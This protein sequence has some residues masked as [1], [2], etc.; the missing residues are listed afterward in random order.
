M[1]TLSIDTFHRLRHDEELTNEIRGSSLRTD[2]AFDNITTLEWSGDK[3]PNRWFC[4]P[5]LTHLLVHRE[6]RIVPSFWQGQVPEITKLTLHR[7]PTIL[8][9]EAPR[10]PTNTDESVPEMLMQFNRLKELVLTIGRS[11]STR[12]K[13]TGG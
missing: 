1:R 11:G 13:A 6:C 12:T 7:L 3:L 2:G 8:N 4:M 10:F 9:A 5:K